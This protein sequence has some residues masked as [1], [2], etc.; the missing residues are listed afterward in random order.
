MRTGSTF[1]ITNQN[2]KKTIFSEKLK[3]KKK[4]THFPHIAELKKK[5][6]P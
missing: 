2:K 3:M 5:N 1:P 6:F 4:N